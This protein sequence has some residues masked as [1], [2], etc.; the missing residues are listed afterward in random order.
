MVDQ[1]SDHAELEEGTAG[2]KP[3]GKAL[4]VVQA[5]LPHCAEHGACEELNDSETREADCLQD[6]AMAGR[7]RRNKVQN[8]ADRQANEA[9][10]DEDLACPNVLHL[11]QFV[12]NEKIGKDHDQKAELEHPVLF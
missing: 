2:D 4:V 7:K 11:S 3:H 8:E 1:E 9:A 5:V 6:V 12:R 10:Y